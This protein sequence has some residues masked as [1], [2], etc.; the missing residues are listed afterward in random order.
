MVVFQHR[1]NSPGSDGLSTVVQADSSFQ[2]PFGESLASDRTL[3]KSA[4]FVILW[5]TWR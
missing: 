3:P 4:I 5:A 1:T 2:F